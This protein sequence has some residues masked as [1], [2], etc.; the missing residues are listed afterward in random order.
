MNKTHQLGGF[1]ILFQPSFLYQS[2][3]IPIRH[4]LCESVNIKHD[5][6]FG[7]ASDGP[8]HYFFHLCCRNSA[9]VNMKTSVSIN[10]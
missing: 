5:V 4:S 3:V 7:L 1:F 8:F 9:I 10:K 6:C 2:P